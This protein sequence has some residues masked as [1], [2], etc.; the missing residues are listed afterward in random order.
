[1]DDFRSPQ[2]RRSVPLRCAAGALANAPAPKQC[3]MPI[4]LLTTGIGSSLPLTPDDQKIYE[5]RAGLLLSGPFIW[6]RASRFYSALFICCWASLYVRSSASRIIWTTATTCDNNWM[7]AI[8]RMDAQM[9][10][11]RLP[12]IPPVKDTVFQSIVI[13]P[14][15]GFV[16]RFFSGNGADTESS[17]YF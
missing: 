2:S 10:R 8:A 7:C 17:V 12:C 3:A 1:M 15:K 5:S 4:L 16:F 14:N 13:R 6:V 11:R 9:C